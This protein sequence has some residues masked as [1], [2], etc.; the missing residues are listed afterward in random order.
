MALLYPFYFHPRQAATERRNMKPTKLFPA[1]HSVVVYHH[2]PEFGVSLEDTLKPEYWAHVAK[3]LRVGHRIEMMASDGSWWAMLIVR[4]AGSH[5]AVL[6]ALQHVPLGKAI[7]PVIEDSP[8]EVKWRGPSRKF[9]VV[10]KEDGEVIK[11]EF[12]VREA[13]AKWMA[14]HMKSLAA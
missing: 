6:Q 8:Y 14:N 9:G 13:A 2:N 7:D 5:D 1:E 11:D 12:D 10:R 3:Q 4:A